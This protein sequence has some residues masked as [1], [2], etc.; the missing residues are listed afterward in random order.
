MELNSILNKRPFEGFSAEANKKPRTSLNFLCE[1]SKPF[2]TPSLPKLSGRVGILYA[3]AAT[4]PVEIWVEIMEHLLHDSV[5]DF[6]NLSQCDKRIHAISKS[7]TLKKMFKSALIREKPIVIERFASKCLK[8][9]DCIAQALRYKNS[10]IPKNLFYLNFPQNS[11]KSVPATFKK[12]I[13]G[14]EGEVKILELSPPFSKLSRLRL[15]QNVERLILD[16]KGG[17]FSHVK[18]QAKQMEKCASNLK[19]LHVKNAIIK[20]EDASHDG[21]RRLMGVSDR[22]ASLPQAVT[23][24]KLVFEDCLIGQIGFNNLIADLPSCAIETYSQFEDRKI[25]RLFPTT[26]FRSFED[27]IHLAAQYV[28]F[29][30]EE[31]RELDFTA[32]KATYH[33]DR[34]LGL[35]PIFHA[36]REFSPEYQVW[37]NAPI[38]EREITPFP[39]GLFSTIV[40]V[41]YAQSYPELR[42][43]HLRWDQIF[44]SGIQIESVIEECERFKAAAP[45]LRT[46]VIHKGGEPIN[47]SA[48]TSS[49][50]RLFSQF[51]AQKLQVI[52]AS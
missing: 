10:T 18:L 19:V 15:F 25:I 31:M 42:T 23:L 48:R 27:E 41:F 34:R 38:F 44:P 12:R 8:T 20:T 16:F 24:E 32:I 3:N 52:R 1:E 46:F 29:A 39:V 33:P 37:L 30:V 26:H 28:G 50:K 36:Q 51:A 2:A 49:L 6:Q 7:E 22:D 21:F 13:K 11:P 35:L 40:R 14:K 47:C 45:K 9:V 17:Y 5:V 43:V 4:I